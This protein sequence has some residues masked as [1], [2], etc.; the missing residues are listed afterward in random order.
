MRLKYWLVSLAGLLCLSQTVLLAASPLPVPSFEARYKGSAYLSNLPIAGELV[1]SLTYE[2]N[3]R[4]RMSSDIRPSGS[5]GLLISASERVIG[6][7][8]SDAI[9]PL[10]YEH[11]VSGVK[12]SRTQLTFHWQEGTLYAEHDDEQATLPLSSGVVDPLSLYLMVMTDLQQNHIRDEYTFVDETEL[13]TYRV[14]RDGKETLQTSLGA[15]P[16]LRVT[17]QEEGSS[18]ITTFWF[19][20]SLEYLPIQIIQEKKGKEVLRM[21]IEEVKGI[22]VKQ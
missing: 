2:E 9:L 17:Q 6:E 22:S 19:A 1:L 14:K 4:Y 20:S 12:S 7:V 16:T 11:Q 10:N 3:D 15:L 8:Q 21:S 5:A 13:K 18:R